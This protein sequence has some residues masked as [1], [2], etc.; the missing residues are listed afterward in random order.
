M[1][2]DIAKYVSLCDTWHRV[3]AEHQRPVGLKQPLK[4]LEL[5]WEKSEW[6]S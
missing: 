4:I 1:K 2:R 6:I 3:K 5:K